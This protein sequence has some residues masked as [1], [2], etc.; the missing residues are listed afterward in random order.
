[1]STDRSIAVIGAGSWGTTLAHLVA[2]NGHPTW[3]WTRDTQRRDEINQRR[4]NTGAPGLVIAPGVMATTNLAE[5]IAGATLLLVAIPSQAF[6]EVCRALGEVLGPQH[7]VI[8]GT[9]GLELGTHRRMSEILREETCVR[10][11]GVLC[12]PN[13][14]GE[15]GQGKPAATV[16][17]SRFPR[18]IETGRRALSSAQ[19]MVFDGQDVE[20]VEL[21]GA[22]KNVVAIA[23]GMA[24]EMDAGQNAKA[25]LV[26]RGMSELMR[27]AFAMGAEPLTLAGLAGM[28]DLIVTCASPL[29]RNHRIGVAIARGEKL[30]DAVKHLGMV[31]EGVHAARSARALARAHGIEMPLFERVDRILHE[32]LA[33]RQAL[34]ELMRLP[35]GHD[36]PAHALRR[37]QPTVRGCYG[38]ERDDTST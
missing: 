22:L 31:A 7:L 35:A 2:S 1:V 26:T 29:S 13:I 18:V 16:I 8:H 14:A 20:G 37:D 12:G 24:D 17:A 21:S 11:I 27:L 38:T 30:D 36:V 4:T 33:P 10:Q 23:A 28:G 25:F 3:L 5:A 19:L 6:R 15:I 32:G 34:E 9:K